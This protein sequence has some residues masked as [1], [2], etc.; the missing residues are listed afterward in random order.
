MSCGHYTSYANHNGTWLHFN[1]HSVKE[2]PVSTV[3]DCKPYI[4]F[5]IR[6]DLNNSL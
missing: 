3:S 6:R 5:Y 4:L 1:D 2:V